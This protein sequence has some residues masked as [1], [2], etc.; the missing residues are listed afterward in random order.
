MRLRT[1]ASI[2]L[3]SA[4]AHAQPSST[5]VALA[6]EL[7]NAGRDLVKEG[8]YA[9][10]CPKLAESARL[11][12]KVGT[13]ARLAECEEHIGKLA[14]ARAHW[15]QASNLAKSTND[16]RVAHAESELARIDRMVPKI[17]IVLSG[18][19]PRDLVLRL[20]DAELG[21]GS[22]GVKLPV[23][24]GKHTIH[25]SAAGKRA[26]SVEMEAK[27]DGVV[28]RVVIPA[29][30]DEASPA[31]VPAPVPPAPPPRE[32][33]PES[34]GSSPLRTIGLATAA[35]GVVGIGVGTV[36]GFVAKS[37]RDD[38]NVQPGGC[39]GNDCPQPAADARNDAR[40]AGNVSTV[41]FVA[42]AV[43][44]AAGVTMFFV[45]PTNARAVRIA[46]VVAKDD[47]RLLFERTW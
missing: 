4:V 20:D 6:T 29:L 47:A 9:A 46:P 39:T 28:S 15:Q 41:F 43:L 24:P 30:A 45:A 34:T 35:V 3:V 25:A 2:V 18:D 33:P 42:G 1:I 40:S 21:A 22:L 32:P 17:E 36:F 16:N 10:A 27:A 7:F 8:N 12:A 5:D 14:S 11:D 44:A 23:D 38:S 37:K 31:P 19:A 13:L 26:A